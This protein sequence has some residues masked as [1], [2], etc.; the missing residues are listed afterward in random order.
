MK[1]RI[2]P[3]HQHR[4]TPRKSSA[5]D[6][7]LSRKNR[8]GIGAQSGYSHIESWE[9]YCPLLIIETKNPSVS[10]ERGVSR[11]PSPD[12]RAALPNMNAR[13]PSAWA[14]AAGDCTENRELRDRNAR[15]C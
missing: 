3:G 8:A 11:M 14:T 4:K 10:V 15:T 13:S 6:T 2:A 12:T 1:R 9:P 7:G 5:T